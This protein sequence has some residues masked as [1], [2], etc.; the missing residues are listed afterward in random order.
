MR[1]ERVSRVFAATAVVSLAACG[2]GGG[3]AGSP[4]PTPVQAVAI[5]ETNAPSVAAE[6]IDAGGAG[7][8]GDAGSLLGLKT[9]SKT[10]ATSPSPMV[11]K[12]LA[13]AVQRSLST[14]VRSTASGTTATQTVQCT[15]G[16]SATITVTYASADVVTPGDSASMAFSNCVEGNSTTNGSLSFTF[17]N[18]NSNVDPTLVV[19][20]LT[21][22]QLTATVG[23]IGE[24]INGGVRLTADS[25]DSTKSVVS[26]AGDSFSFERLVN[27]TARASRKL[28]NYS[29]RIETGTATGTTSE[30]FA[31]SASGSFPRF[32]TVSFEAHTTQAVVTPGNA[33]YPTAGAGKVT[34][35]NGTSVTITVVADGVDLGVDSNGDGTVD[36]TLHRTWQQFDA[37]L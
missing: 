36:I 32:G 7:L 28:S 27:G 15:N 23:G 37:E 2:G 33:S 17:V 9:S 30:T 29:Y 8:G 3:D 13:S 11:L 1:V 35:A 34:G 19:V 14:Q 22:S 31:Y 5:T 10:S 6:A 12:S 21:A 26:V 4:A 20:D 25:T 24:R 16:G 18:I